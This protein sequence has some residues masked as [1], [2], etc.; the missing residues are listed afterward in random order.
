LKKGVLQQANIDPVAGEE[1][2]EEE[3]DL[4]RRTNGLL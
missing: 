4:K 2:G 1:K 3:K